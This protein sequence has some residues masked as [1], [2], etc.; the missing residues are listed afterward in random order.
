[1]G[2]DLC[3]KGTAS[4]NWD[5]WRSCLNVAQLFGWA[6]METLPPA[7]YPVDWRGSYYFNECQTV[8]APDARALASA[9]FRAVDAV[10]G[11]QRLTIKQAAALSEAS[12]DMMVELADLAR[13][14]AFRIY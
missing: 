1:M 7:D 3:G 8:S 2:V 4:L 11:N 13:K 5:A 12:L 14:G 10:R 9:L 6:P